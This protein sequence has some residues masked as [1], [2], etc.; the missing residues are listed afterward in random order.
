MLAL[1]W[2]RVS[3]CHRV[4]VVRRRK[5]FLTLRKILFFMF[6]TYKVIFCDILEL[7]LAQNFKTKVLTVQKNNLLECLMESLLHQLSGYTFIVVKNTH[8][9]AANLMFRLILPAAMVPWWFLGV[10]YDQAY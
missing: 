10:Q 1:A 6:H 3:K 8:Q 9:K 7:F 5:K 4:T 2:L